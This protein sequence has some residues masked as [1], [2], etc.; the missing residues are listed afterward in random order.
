MAGELDDHEV[1]AIGKRYG[2]DSLSVVRGADACSVVAVCGER[3]RIVDFLPDQAL[4]AAEVEHATAVI[5]EAY[6]RGR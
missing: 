6:K 2:I 5:A 4:S 3:V 1:S